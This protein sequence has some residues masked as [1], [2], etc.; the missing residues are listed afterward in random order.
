MVVPYPKHSM[1]LLSLHTYIWL[2]EGVN[3]E[4]TIHRHSMYGMFAY[5]NHK[6]QQNVG[7]YTMYSD[8]IG[9]VVYI[10]NLYNPSLTAIPHKERRFGP[11]GVPNSHLLTQYIW[12]ILEW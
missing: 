10:S 12:R 2:L 8:P 7:K 9:L 3:V 4:Y 6:H 11:L 5:V 1:F